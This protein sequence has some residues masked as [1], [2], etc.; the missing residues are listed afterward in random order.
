VAALMARRADVVVAVSE[1]CA[2]P[3][4]ASGVEPRIVNPAVPD[5]G[6]R[7]HRGA[8]GRIVVGTLGTVAR[9]KG[10]DLFV[11]AARR[12][13]DHEGI[14]FRIAGG[15]NAGPERG[16]AEALLEQARGLGVVH[17]AWVDPYEEL[18]EWDVLVAPS[19]TD[20]FPLTVLE[21]MAM[22]LPVVGARVGGIPEQLGHDAG[23]LFEPDDVNGLVDA[24]RRLADSQ[25]LRSSLGAAAHRRRERLFTL[26][27]QAEQLESAYLATLA[28]ARAA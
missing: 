5:P 25:S 16:W 18:A 13:R 7:P 22:G 10:S 8:D 23:L 2:K 6:E 24:V 17:R 27:R 9:H 3:L 14:E 15:A 4:R 20:A 1:A 21:A 12:L 19:R 11:E 26:E 28:S